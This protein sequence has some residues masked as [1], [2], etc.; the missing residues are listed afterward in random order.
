M[1]AI[2]NIYTIMKIYINT[3]VCQVYENADLG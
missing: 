2:R 1:H 3:Y